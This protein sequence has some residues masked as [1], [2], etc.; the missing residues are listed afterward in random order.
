MV[1]G[2]HRLRQPNLNFV[3]R[4]SLEYDNSILPLIRHLPNPNP[5][6]QTVARTPRIAKY[7]LKPNFLQKVLKLKLHYDLKQ[8]CNSKDA[9]S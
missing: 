3:Q 4:I 7:I 5:L 2:P 1:T 8:K 9:H 6:Q